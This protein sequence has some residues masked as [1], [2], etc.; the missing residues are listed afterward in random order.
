ERLEAVIRAF[1]GVMVARGDLG[2]EMPLER[3][4]LTQKHAV[5]L[6]REHAK[7]VIVATQML[8]SMIQHSRPTRAEASD[9]ANAVLDGADALMLSGETGVGRYPIETVQTMARVIEASEAQA[10][11]ALAGISRRRE[12]RGDAIAAAAVRV[13]E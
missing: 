2:V 3:V 10:L 6:A 12:S 11:A 4:P 5:H 13:A 7:P 9:V 8:E 1:D